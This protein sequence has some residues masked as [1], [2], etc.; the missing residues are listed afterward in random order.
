M[1]VTMQVV[2]SSKIKAIGY[3]EKEMILY[4]EF[5]TGSTY[6]YFAVEPD[7][8]ESFQKAESKGKFFG[9]YI[10]G[11]D[12]KNPI[13][14]FERVPAKVEAGR[15][16]EAAPAAPAVTDTIPELPA[17]VQELPQRALAVQK[18]AQEIQIRTDAENTQAAN[19]LKT[20]KA[21]RAIV[22][23]RVDAFKRP[24][25]EAWKAANA[26]EREAIGP[27]E[28]AEKMIK[29]AMLSF[30]RAEE[31]KRRRAE[32]EE[33]RI[34]EQKAREEAEQRSRDEAEREASYA[35]A[36]GASKVEVEEIRAN[37][38]PVAP[39]PIAPVVLPSTV[40]KTAGVS[41]REKWSFRIVDER[42][43]PREYLMVNESAI[44]AVATTQK[45]L[46]KIPGVEFFD[47]GTV[48]VR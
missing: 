31:E 13:Y 1:N 37:P 41:R 23:A 17:D 3:D 35:A 15:I 16:V 38:L 27:Y 26:L 45:K 10:A 42:L 11:P 48:V 34:L 30:S 40:T 20:L 47:E 22:Q 28:E 8:F 32:A 5:P 43:I 46:A 36:Q 39:V 7:V 9:A 25:V 6:R 12:R 44:R 24:A 2:S 18:Q 29:A 4:I 21:E 19:T 33:R 14:R